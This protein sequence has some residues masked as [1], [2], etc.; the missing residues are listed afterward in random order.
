MTEDIYIRY[1]RNYYQEHRTINDIPHNYIVEFEGQ[2]LNIGI[3]FNTIKTRHKAYINGT[4][5]SGAKSS[6][7]LKRYQALDEMNYDWDDARLKKENDVVEEPQIRYLRKYFEEHGTINDIGISDIVEFE[8]ENLKIGSYLRSI[9]DKHSLYVKGIFKRANNTKAAL[10]RYAILDELKIDWDNRNK[11]REDEVLSEPAIRYLQSYYTEFGTINDISTKA[12]VEFEGEKLR[13][14]SY[15]NCLRERHRY[16]LAGINKKASFSEASLARYKLLDE[17]NFSWETEQQKVSIKDDYD[18]YIEYL[19]EYYQQH[20]TLTGATDQEEVEYN[21]QKLNIR[22][23]INQTR[24]AYKCY[25]SGNQNQSFRSK[26]YLRRYAALK[27]LNFSFEAQVLVGISEIAK[28]H[29]L[30]PKTLSTLTKKFDGDIDKAIKIALLRKK[31][32]KQVRKSHKKKYSLESVSKEFEMDI[33]K[34]ANTLN[35]ETLQSSKPKRKLMYSKT[36][37]LRE[38]CIQNGLNYSVISKAVRL[39]MNNLCEEDLASLINRCIVEYKTNGQKKPSTWIYSK[40]GN[41]L[42]VRH[43]ILSLSFDP[44]SILSDMSKGALSIEEAFKNESYRRYF[45]Q[46]FSYLKPIYY[47]LV[48]FSN[49][50][51]SNE[52]DSEKLNEHLKELTTEYHL[53]AEELNAMN[54]ALTH[55]R[56]AVLKYRLFDVA[57]EKDNDKRLAKVIEYNLSEEEIEETFFLPLQFD[58][59]VLL[60]RDSELYKRRMLLRKLITSWSKTSEEERQKSINTNQLTEAELEYVDTTRKQMNEVKIKVKKKR[61]EEV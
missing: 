34:L 49:E 26:L 1:L 33:E 16:Y 53:T 10:L 37:S 40:Y 60:G 44:D 32:L 54:K 19:K 57:F 22:H 5:R 11:K 42:L 4:T 8:G 51:I 18:P 6:L 21:G 9:R 2:T 50:T 48:S 27:E 3:F 20:G 58:E 39:R 29:G 61:I 35:K 38:F 28:E 47:D 52:K 46:S 59:K 15:L 25:L 17:M 23:F 30:N 12:V 14:G 56:T 43:L 45:N 13:I 55:Y 41:E 24:Y 7:S 36:M 31:S